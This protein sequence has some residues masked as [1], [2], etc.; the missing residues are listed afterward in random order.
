MQIA[1]ALLDSPDFI[2]LGPDAVAG[3]PPRLRPRGA[4]RGCSSSCERQTFRRLGRKPCGGFT[5]DLT[6]AQVHQLVTY[7]IAGADGL[8]NRQGDRAGDAGG[9][10]SPLFELHAWAPLRQAGGA[11]R[12]VSEDGRQ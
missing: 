2:R 9:T 10:C 1:K 8:F 7:A 6:D 3:T 5:P 4:R 11:L 12:L